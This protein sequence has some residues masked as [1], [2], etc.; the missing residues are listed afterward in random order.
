[1]VFQVYVN[2]GYEDL[3]E[4][5]APEAGQEQRGWRARVSPEDHPVS[6]YEFDVLIGKQNSRLN[7]L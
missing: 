5:T 3:I 7:R 1:M 6:S 4:P 2:V